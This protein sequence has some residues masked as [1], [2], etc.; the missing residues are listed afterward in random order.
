MDIACQ[1]VLN[2]IKFNHLNEGVNRLTGIPTNLKEIDN[3]TS[4]LQNELYVIAA[5]PSNGKTALAMQIAANAAIYHDKCGAIYSMETSSKK[6]TTRIISGEAMVNSR[7]IAFYPLTEQDVER[8]RNNID[9]IAKSKLLFD[10]SCSKSLFSILSSIRN[11]KIKYDID[12][13][14]ID[15]IQLVEHTIK[16]G[17]REQVI[18]QI[19]R[20]IKNL[21]MELNIPIIALSQLS[22]NQHSPLP[23]LSRL[24]ESGEIEAAADVIIL[25][26]Y[27]QRYNL[28][29]PQPYENL[30][31]ENI[32]WAD[33][34]KG[35][36]SGTKQCLF[37]FEPQYTKFS[38]Y[39]ESDSIQVY[40]NI[41]KD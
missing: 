14:V 9:K 10:D 25:L 19:I 29:L 30:N 31:N 16:G 24:K 32:V 39:V 34:A 6:L 21:Q 13:A 12:F 26:H 41:F 33:F 20:S 2:M 3:F 1:E 4:G 8:V 28:Q 18:S 37:K 27:A 7:A 36:N 17:S 5:E 15:Y 11:L 35:K 38:N 40:D 23:T 22:K